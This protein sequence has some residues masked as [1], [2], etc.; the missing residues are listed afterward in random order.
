M[1]KKTGRTLQFVSAFL[2]AVLCTS[3][4]GQPTPPILEENLLQKIA[5][6][7]SGSICFE[8]IRFLSTLNRIWGSKDY[9]RA[10]QYCVDKCVEYGLKKAEI[11]EFP[12][13]TGR[14]SFWM[15]STGGYVPWD[16]KGGEFRL[17]EPYPMLLS[18]YENAPSTIA[19][20]SRSSDVVSELV[21]IGRGDAVE[22]YEGRDVRGK[23][24]LVE[25]GRHAR[26][27]ELA[28]HQFGALGTVHFY[29]DGGQYWE[30]EG[31][32]WANI[33]PWSDDR[34]KESTFGINISSS[35]GKF[36]KGLLADKQKVI[37][38][39]KIEAE[40]IRDG[41]FELATAII[42][43]TMEPEEEFIF[44]AHLDHPKPGAHDNASGDA[45]LLEIARTLASLIQKGIIPAPRRTIRFMWIPHMCGLNMYFFSHPEKLGKVKA[46]CNVD[47]VGVD[48]ARFPTQFHVALPP[49][50]LPSYLTDITLNLVDYVNDLII[51][52]KNMLFAPEG[53]RSLFT[54][55][56][57]PYQGGSD[58]YTA[59]TRTLNIPSIYF[60]EEPLPPRHNQINFLEYL[61]RTNLNRICYLGAIISYAFT[62]AGEEMA[63]GL[64]I[65]LEYR[66]KT[67][68]EQELTKARHLI[69]YSSAEDIHRNYQMGMNLLY[70]GRKRE[71]GM[72]KSME[73]MAMK[74][75][76]LRR[77]HEDVLKSILQN[78]DEWL[79]Q[80]SRNYEWKCQALGTRPQKGT[81][82]PL[83]VRWE[84][85]IPSFNP[86]IKGSIGYFSNYLEDR[87]GEDFLKEYPGVRSSIKYGNVGYYEAVNYIDGR[88]SVADIFRAVEAELW[89]EDYSLYHQLKFEELV[90][91]FRLLEDAGVIAMKTGSL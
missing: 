60:Y 40:V 26:A 13:K 11:E 51:Q 44:Y 67:R 55:V 32:Y 80:L 37:V 22:R 34:K 39:V 74:H 27:H 69:E 65:E 71:L 33:N 4:S 6:E 63:P 42:P 76:H 49:H 5:Q 43:G 1:S 15:H 50:S 57:T 35:Q 91:F 81:A 47:C 62:A 9:H 28:V 61:D 85:A 79:K 83:D 3:V 68:L 8:H 86:D 82:P 77:L 64:M 72:L 21:Y 2:F 46:G 12:I 54:T 23:I 17:V 48:P 58:E 88:N 53:S 19:P 56:L 90:N 70:W 38:S 7:V 31:I 25:G 20:M 18:H 29:E 84:K 16:L 87:L 24:V 30:S 75:A 41:V 73:G 66:G 10:A 89:S 59:N 78:S 14:E 45:A 36:L 52:E